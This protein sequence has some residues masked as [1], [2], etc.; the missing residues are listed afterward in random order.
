MEALR[1]AQLAAE[2]YRF[3]LGLA[4][5][6]LSGKA[7]ALAELQGQVTALLAQAAQVRSEQCGDGRPA[8]DEEEWAEEPLTAGLH[9]HHHEDAAD[10]QRRGRAG[11]W[12]ADEREMRQLLARVE[13]LRA[14]ELEAAS[15]RCKL[16]QAEGREEQ[17][18]QRVLA[19]EAEGAGPRAAAGGGARRRDGGKE[20]G[21][22]SARLLVETLVQENSQLRTRL[23]TSEVSLCA[24]RKGLGWKGVGEFVVE[25]TDDNLH[26]R[27]RAGGSSWRLSS[28]LGLSS[29]RSTARASTPWASLGWRA[30]VGSGH[31]PRSAGT[32]R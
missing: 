9:A 3:Q 6:E 15:Y 5:E 26:P 30:T 29:R 4:R 19:L 12:G 10:G 27:R 31:P 14:S 8:H 1:S 22:A 28:R 7:A 23:L 13:E 11:G 17:L 2:H 25:W 32:A 16:R 20:G 18:R 24:L 21:P